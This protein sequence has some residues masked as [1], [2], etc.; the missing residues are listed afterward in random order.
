MFNNLKNIYFII[1]LSYQPL[2]YSYTLVYPDTL[3]KKKKQTD[4]PW[5]INIDPD[6][7]NIYGVN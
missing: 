6:F 2:N 3:D 4:K 5:N 7:T 1:T